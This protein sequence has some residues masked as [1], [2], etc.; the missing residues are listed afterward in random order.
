MY[1][2][3]L[4]SLLNCELLEFSTTGME[5]GP[6]LLTS[7]PGEAGGLRA[8]ENKAAPQNEV[9]IP[10]PGIQSFGKSA[11]SDLS[12]CYFSCIPISLA[13][14]R[15]KKCIILFYRNHANVR[16]YFSSLTSVP[17]HPLCTP[18]PYQPMAMSPSA[19]LSRY[20]NY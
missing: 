15:N 19:E 20:K 13:T 2:S 16:K 8:T 3:Y 6:S 14:N 1:Y 17:T 7:I 12:L 18:S 4:E 10:Y 5:P 11:P 9:Q